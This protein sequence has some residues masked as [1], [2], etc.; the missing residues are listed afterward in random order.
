MSNRWLYVLPLLMLVVM[1]GF[2]GYAL[3]QNR[4]PADIGEPL[5]G[6]P[7]PAIDLAPLQED[8][9]RLT[10]AEWQGKVTVLN[11]F[12]SWCAPCLAE[13]PL[14]LR[15][16]E[17]GTRLQGVNYRNK[18]DEAKAWLARLGN[19]YERIG[20]DPEGKAGVE[21]GISGVPE[22]FVIDKTGIVRLH[23]RRPLTA[24]DVNKTILPLVRELSK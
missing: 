16:K 13:H 8:G 10:S 5:L 6:R 23:L 20:V 1:A 18:A 7:A 17:Q 11:F 24:D 2:F 19:P 3:T 22:T 4:N 15:L 14:F 21:F 12:A 9:A